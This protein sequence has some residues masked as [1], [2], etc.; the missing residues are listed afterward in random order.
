MPLGWFA[1]GDRHAIEIASFLC[2]HGFAIH[3]LLPHRI[4]MFLVKRNKFLSSNLIYHDIH[5]PLHQSGILTYYLIYFIKAVFYTS[6]TNERFDI[7]YCPGHNFELLFIAIVAKLKNHESKLIVWV[8]H[9][10]PKPK[11]RAQFRRKSLFES[12]FDLLAYISQEISIIL[13]KK[14]G[15]LILTP[16]HLMKSKIVK[17]G[18]HSSKIVQLGNGV[19][20]EYINSIQG[21]SNEIEGCAIGTSPSKGIVDMLQAWAGVNKRVKDAKLLIIGSPGKLRKTLQKCIT[22]LNLHGRITLG[23][24]VTENKKIR[25]LKSSKFFISPTYEEGWSLAISEAAACGL[26][27]IAYDNPIYREVYG[28]SILYVP[29][30]N[31]SK[32]ARVIVTLLHNS[33]LVTEYSNKSKN[34][35]INHPWSEVAKK[36][37]NIIEGLFV[38]KCRRNKL[39]LVGGT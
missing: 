31:T 34:W 4:H 30:G 8:H 7:I 5:E 3:V 27:V 21:R 37:K 22:N 26:P 29:T 36:E 6:K 14:H 32:L 19:D 38:L 13:A 33:Q 20:L 12:F 28:N 10:I 23:D 25:I 9:L 1:G 11:V 17:K 2:K 39:L 16:T 35:A 24:Y 15:D 18:I